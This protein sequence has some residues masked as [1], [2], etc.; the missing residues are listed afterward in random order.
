MI[1]IGYRYRGNPATSDDIF[2]REK[3]VRKVEMIEMEVEEVRKVEII[4]MGL[5]SA[6]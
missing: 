4:E 3:E 5:N 2:V 6:M 1:R